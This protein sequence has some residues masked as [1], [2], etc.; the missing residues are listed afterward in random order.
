MTIAFG[1]MLAPAPSINR[2]ALTEAL[3]GLG[4]PVDGLRSVVIE[5]RQVTLTVYAENDSG[6]KI[7]LGDGVVSVTYSIPVR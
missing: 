5:P 6:Q 2:D 7:P 3:K 1:T 4:I